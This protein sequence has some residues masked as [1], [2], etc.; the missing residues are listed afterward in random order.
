VSKLICPNCQ[1]PNVEEF[2]MRADLRLRSVDYHECVACASVWTT[3]KQTQEFT[4]LV[5]PPPL[6]TVETDRK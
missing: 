2:V 4:G 1:S 5:T 3:D 6:P